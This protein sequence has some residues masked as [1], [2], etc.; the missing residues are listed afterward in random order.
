[1]RAIHK[2]NNYCETL[3]SLH[4]P[5]WAIPL[6]DPLPTKLHDLREGGSLLME[7][8]W[9]ARSPGE[10]PR[11]LEDLDVREGIRAM[12]KVDRCLEEQCR[13][14]LEADNLC[15]AFGR[16]LCALELAIANPSSKPPTSADRTDRLMGI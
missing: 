4:Q 7:D 9:I 6:P 14:G 15:R 2:F 1:M 8:V 12:L 10:M 16:E 3:A 5:E 11:W 13:L